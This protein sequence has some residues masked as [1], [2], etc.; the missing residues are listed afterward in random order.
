[1]TYIVKNAERTEKRNFNKVFGND[2]LKYLAEII[3]NSDDSYNRLEQA[4]YIGSDV[5]CPIYIHVTNS[6]LKREV[7]VVDNAEGMNDI[8]LLRNFQEYGADTSGGATGKK[9][10]GLFGQGASDVLFNASLNGKI[11]EICSFKDDTFYV[12]KFR[13]DGGN[14]VINPQRQKKSM[15]DLRNLRDHYKI[16][17][18]GTAVR[19]GLPK[20]V[21][22]PRNF[23]QAISSFYILRFILSK[24]NRQI[25]FIEHTNGGVPKETKLEYIFPPLIDEDILLSQDIHFQ[26]AGDKVSGKLTLMRKPQQESFGTLHVLCYDKQKSVY[27][28]T[29]FNYEKYPNADTIHGLLELDG[30]SDI[31]R[32]K[33]N[34]DIP[35]EI[36]TDT[37]DG[38]DKRHTFYKELFSRVEPLLQTVLE[39]LSRE[40]PEKSVEL[41]DQREWRDAFKEINKYFQEELEE[42]IG[43]VETGVNPPPEG[44]RFAVPNIKIT[45]GRKYST[46]LLINGNLLPAGSIISL[47]NESPDIDI[48]PIKI[49]ITDK[50]IDKNSLAVK[51]ISISGLIVGTESTV[52]A[53]SNTGHTSKL[54][55]SVI[56][57]EIHYPKYGFEFVPSH[58]RLRANDS[59]VA[60]LFINIEKIPLGS[61]IDF[62]YDRSLMLLGHTSITLSEEHLV[63]GNIAKVETEVAS[64]E[65]FAQT[66]VKASVGSTVA[67]LSVDISDEEDQDDKG[68]GG[69][70]N[71]V[72]V[73]AVSSFW[74]TFFDHRDGRIN[75]NSDNAVNKLHLGI[76]NPDNFKPTKDQRRFLVDLCANEAAKQ[77]VK[78]KIGKGKIPSDSYEAVL[79]EIQKEKNKLLGIFV[80]TLD[81]FIM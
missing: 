14:K 11:A 27:D 55:V 20:D 58:T 21:T 46:K 18:N 39:K 66:G 29:L 72:T 37:R 40:K 48:S 78:L 60:K 32:K 45:A 62:D 75:I 24:Q 36:L 17:N 44:L 19:F 22:I 16:P 43:G 54:F 42:E 61:V 28:N 79:D 73:K 30:A 13:W 76:V 5:I 71:G 7:L 34:Q 38:F 33:L 57:R 10:R 81:S 53:T 59:M 9:V 25:V 47:T 2:I 31:I 1:M 74:Q 41:T 15:S 68:R 63:A 77:L 51:S 80:K 26:Y 3:T 50:D 49:T 69:F 64:L 70:L 8:D 52:I 67:V 35:E 56:D 6:R 12:C 65:V 23:A 4:G